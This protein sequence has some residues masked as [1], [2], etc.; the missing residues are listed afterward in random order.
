M[1]DSPA[2]LFGKEFFFEAADPA[3]AVFKQEEK[4]R[5]LATVPL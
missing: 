1:V 3:G 4:C 5:R 2:Q